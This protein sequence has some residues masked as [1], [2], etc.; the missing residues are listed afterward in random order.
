VIF[1]QR[2]ELAF[3]DKRWFQLL[4]TGRAIPVMTAHIVDLKTYAAANGRRG[5][6][7]SQVTQTM[8]LYPLPVREV[9]TNVGLQQNPGY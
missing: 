5:S 6:L 8:L 1:E 4:R 7:A 2:V 3:E 9:T